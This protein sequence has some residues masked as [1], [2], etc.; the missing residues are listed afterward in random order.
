MRTKDEALEAYKSY[1]AWALAQ[2]HCKAIKVLRSDRGG[3]YLS[4]VFDQHLA[5]AGTMQKLTTHDTPQLNGVAKWL[6]R[7]LLERIQAFMHTSGLPKT[8]W[9]EGLRHTTWLKNR[10]ATR[11]LDGKMPFEALFGAPPDLSGLCLWGCPV[12][13][14][15]AAG[16][17][18]DVRAR[19]GCWIGLDV[20]T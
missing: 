14:H 7:T 1:E 6:N 2:Q 9:G 10:T 8:L 20:D 4:K 15:N 18:L 12:W 17:K 16:A 19:Q 13:V 11:T 3:E 5:A